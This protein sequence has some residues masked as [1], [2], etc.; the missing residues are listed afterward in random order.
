MEG[1]KARRRTDELG[2]LRK[3]EGVWR[4]GLG[5]EAWEEGVQSRKGG[6]MGGKIMPAVSS[7]GWVAVKEW[8]WK[9]WDWRYSWSWEV[10]PFSGSFLV[11]APVAQG[12]DLCLSVWPPF[13]GGPCDFVELTLLKDGY[14]SQTP[15]GESASPSGPSDW[16]R[17]EHVTQAGPIRLSW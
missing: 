7:W 11:Q 16:L 14:E 10:F 17:M 3:G 9:Q 12:E 13:F 4:F 5:Q 1:K 15:P 6:R 2:G 8:R